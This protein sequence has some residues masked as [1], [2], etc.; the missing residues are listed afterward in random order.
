MCV[1][2]DVPL[3]ALLGLMHLR[4][5]ALLLIFG[6][7][8]GGDD[9][10]IDNRGLPHQQTALLQH[11]T[12]F[13]EQRSGQI[14]ALQPMAEVQQR[15]RVRDGIHE[16]AIRRSTCAARECWQDRLSGFFPSHRCDDM[17]RFCE[18][19]NYPNNGPVWPRPP[20]VPSCRASLE[21]QTR[22][23]RQ[24]ELDGNCKKM[25]T[26][27][28]ALVFVLSVVA[29]GFCGGSVAAQGTNAA[30]D[31]TI[32]NRG[33]V[34]LETGGFGDAYARIVEEIASIVDDGSTRRVIPV[35]GKG[36]LQSV[37]DLLYLRGI[38]LAIVQLDA[39]EYVRVQRLLPATN[40]IS[41][42]TKLYNQELHLLAGRDV[43]SIADLANKTV[44]VD[45][46]GSGTAFTA[47]RLFDLLKIPI[48]KSSDSP[49]IAL[50]KL[51]RGEI[52]ALA[53]VTPKPAPLFQLLKSGDGLQL[54]TIPLTSEITAAYAPSRLTASDYP[55]LVA[56]DRPVDTIAVGM[57]LLA[58]DLR[59]VPDRFRNVANVVDAFFTGF[60]KLLEP[61]HHPKWQEVN[62]AAAVPG[63][64][65]Y[66]PAEQWIQRNMAVA[67][68]PSP[69]M[70]KTLFSRF[71]DERRSASGGAAMPAEEKE[72]LFQQFRAW[73]QGQRQ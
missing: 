46:R 67:S 63:L 43:K 73:Q 61:G 62:I 28:A 5:A 72:R 20:L 8:R 71:I 50:H 53:L 6:R 57:V 17:Q 38:D 44:N 58:A 56:P 32:V 22:T 48:M 3:V 14:V 35:L 33:V 54:L 41:F 69:E 1:H 19:R 24:L 49:E 64:A 66:Q 16:L 15:R 40:S 47:E 68:A 11:R 25:I 39:F 26:A 21:M 7:R 59:M 37:A 9:R 12:H 18:K 4:V 51:R 30:L 65:R 27:T 10:G 55:D 42:V 34:Q 13:V 70:L 29:L 2:P 52:A 36:P 23:R 60:Q 45:Q 31:A